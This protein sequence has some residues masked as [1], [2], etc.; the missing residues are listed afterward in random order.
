[1]DTRKQQR[2]GGPGGAYHLAQSEPTPDIYVV[3]PS[4]LTALAG[5]FTGYQWMQTL[6]E[7]ALEEVSSKSPPRR[8]RLLLGLFITSLGLILLAPRSLHHHVAMHISHAWN[9]KRPATRVGKR[10]SHSLYHGRGCNSTQLLAD[11]Q[12]ARISPSG[13]SRRKLASS[14][15]AT[16]DLS[17][18][19]FSY[20]LPNC[21]D[22]HI[23]SAQETCDL[24]GAFGGVF[25]RG[26]SLVRHMSQSLMFL[27]TNSL[28]VV[29]A[30]HQNCTGEDLFSHGRQCRLSSYNDLDL[31]GSVC[32][33]PPYIKYEQVWRFITVAYKR[34]AIGLKYPAEDYPLVENPAG[35]FSSFLNTLPLS[36]QSLSPI[37]VLSAGI[38]FDFRLQDAMDYHISPYLSNTTS[39]T[40][41]PISLWSAYSAPSPRK[42]AKF[43]AKQG[44]EVVKKF[45][46]DVQKTLSVVSPG[47]VAFGAMRSLEWYGATDGAYSYDGTHHSYLVNMEKAQYALVPHF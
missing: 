29:S 14:T 20:E 21:P 17:R 7:D 47:E 24:L 32:A 28:D 44:A 9:D 39:L 34:A 25:L 41:R 23:F 1:M 15:N 37:V 27:L 38:H 30:N 4:P 33:K 19:D 18:F 45:N 5:A 36:R 11:L 16:L 46:G 43:R 10:D 3:P 12:M 40:P 6:R 35:N 22:P 31:R 13:A 42:P 26:D 8:F 2:Y